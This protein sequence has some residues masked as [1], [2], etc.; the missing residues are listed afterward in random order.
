MS[1]VFVR[2]MMIC[3]HNPLRSHYYCSQNVA[4]IFYSPFIDLYSATGI[5]LL[6]MGSIRWLTSKPSSN[7]LFS[8]EICIIQLILL[9]ELLK[10]IRL[11]IHRSQNNTKIH[12]L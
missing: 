1:A 8:Q 2:F 4:T 7:K 12:Q 11:H 9:E 5:F 6:I 10:K 3:P